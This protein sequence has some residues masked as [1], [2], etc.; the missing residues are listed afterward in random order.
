[1]TPAPAKRF[2]IECR[3]EDGVAVL[4]PSGVFDMDLLD[5]AFAR[6][7]EFVAALPPRAGAVLNFGLVPFLNSRGIGRV[8]D[9]AANL[10]ESGRKL[11]IAHAD[12][13]MDALHICG[14]DSII[15]VFPDLVAAKASVSSAGETLFSTRPDPVK[16]AAPK[17]A[18][19]APKPAAAGAE[20]FVGP[21]D[22]PYGAAPVPHVRDG[23][24]NL[25]VDLS[26]FGL[27]ASSSDAP[28]PAAAPEAAAVP[29]AVAAPVLVPV[30]PAA[31]ITAA[32]EVSA[33]SLI[34]FS[35]AASAAEAPAPEKPSRPAADLDGADSL[36]EGTFSADPTAEE[37]SIL[38]AAAAK[39]R[40]NLSS[41]DSRRADL[42]AAMLAKEKKLSG[43]RS[44]LKSAKSRLKDL[45][46]EA[47]K[48][49]AAIA[50]VSG[51]PA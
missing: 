48:V 31:D 26:S 36:A 42:E 29:P 40:A 14:I 50:C 1:M 2:E 8:A 3:V 15:P 6:A 47:E 25:E 21:D 30:P 20:I 51:K 32:P 22:M 24:G 46:K 41:F 49:S 12:D 43:L 38:A 45:E 5:A 9:M 18:P 16:V 4:T 7:S 39:L 34:S 35:D 11:A 19:A 27:S 44:D 28:S 23:D 17:S 13:V 37:A 33:E 10:E